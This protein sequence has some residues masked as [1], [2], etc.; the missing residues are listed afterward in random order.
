ML[1]DALTRYAAQHGHTWM[2]HDY[3]DAQ[4]FSL[5]QRVRD[6]RR[7][8]ASDHAHPPRLAGE[9]EAVPGWSWQ[10]LKSQHVPMLDALRAF[11]AREGH[12]LVP[13]TWR[14]GDVPLGLWEQ[15]RRHEH[16]TGR[17]RIA[18]ALTML[19]EALPYWTW[20]LGGQPTRRFVALLRSPAST[21]TSTC[22]ARADWRTRDWPTGPT[23]CGPGTRK[24]ACPATRRP[25][26]S[27]SP[28]GAGASPTSP[29][30]RPG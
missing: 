19:L 10:G 22:P 6:L 8:Y 5:G 11:V 28:P 15:Q 29:R 7:A 17:R 20:G 16:R 26:S 12:A 1:L 13:G 24:V 4:G 25:S 23:R 14:E 21:A 3:L 27:G 2:A 9:L 30:R 18:P